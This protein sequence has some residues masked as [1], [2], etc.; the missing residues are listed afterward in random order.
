MCKYTTNKYLKKYVDKENN[1][2]KKIILIKR[3]VLF[4]RLN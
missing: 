2:N 1:N 4:C 3:R